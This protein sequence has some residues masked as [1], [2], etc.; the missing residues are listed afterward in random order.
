M[1]LVTSDDVQQIYPNPG[2]DYSPFIVTADV[3][4][5]E[6]LLGQGFSSD[7]LRLIELYLA[8]H[9]AAISLEKGGLQRQKIGDGEDWYQPIEQSAAGLSTTR[10]GQ[11]A[12]V[13]DTSGVLAALSVKPVK[14]Q[15]RVVSRNRNDF[16]E[17]CL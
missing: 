3:L 11:Q 2:E 17:G 6:T 16:S 4:V 12:L 10:F 13:L 8:A 5:N 9:Y 1:A 15:F 14:A 7:R